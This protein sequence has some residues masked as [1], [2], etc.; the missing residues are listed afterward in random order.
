MHGQR[1]RRE[2]VKREE[3]AQRKANLKHM[4]R[5]RT[6]DMD[7]QYRMENDPF[8]QINRP[9]ITEEANAELLAQTIA[10]SANE[11]QKTQQASSSSGIKTIWGTPAIA[12]R[13]E[14]EEP[15][16]VDWPDHVVV[17]ERKKNRKKKK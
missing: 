4:R 10:L 8:F 5:T 16:P 15:G 13:E 6:E 9:P 12:T 7:A 11:A 1:E 14:E 3:T 17:V 2:K